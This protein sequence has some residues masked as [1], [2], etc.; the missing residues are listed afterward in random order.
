MN[1]AL[2]HAMGIERTLRG[3]GGG[4]EAKTLHGEG[5]ERC[6]TVGSIGKKTVSRNVQL[7]V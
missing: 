6:D 2:Y 3:G 1:S 4:E 7:V 5:W